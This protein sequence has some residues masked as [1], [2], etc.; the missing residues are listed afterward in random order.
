MKKIT[1]LLVFSLL[2]LFALAVD[3][4]NTGILFGGN[5]K[6]MNKVGLQLYSLREQFKSDVPGTLSKVK[7]MGF[8]KVELAGTYGM[9]PEQF[10]SELD[11]FHL[12]PVSMHVG[13]ERLRDD[14]DSV[15]KEA[16]TFGVEYVGCAWIPHKGA[17]TADDCNRAIAHFNE[18]GE[19]LAK[20]GLRFMYHI[21]GYEFQSTEGG[22]LYDK[23]ITGTKPQYVA[24]EMDVFWVVWPGQ[25]PV[26]LLK[27]YP[28][29]VELLH[30]KDLKKGLKGNLSGGAPPEAETSLGTGQVDWPKVLREAMKGGVKYMFIEDETAQV[31]FQIPLSLSYLR[32]VKY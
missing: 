11:R 31:E 16:K 3:A 32:S 7:Q 27:K 21:H 9:K 19:K 1:L 13:Y 18:W 20:H 17:F 25:D 30:L 26:Q 12:Q 23:L 5:E 10:K 15:I 24:I 6:L 28:K 14:L 8:T 2:S 22:T 4:Q 29:R